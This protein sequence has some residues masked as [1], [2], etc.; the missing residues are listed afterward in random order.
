[1]KNLNILNTILVAISLI[2]SGCTEKPDGITQEAA[3]FNQAEADS[4][5]KMAND[6]FMRL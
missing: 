1:M 2:W 3:A 5:L 4:T 6:A